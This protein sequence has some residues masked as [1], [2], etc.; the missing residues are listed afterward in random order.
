[1]SVEA[2][3]VAVLRGVVLDGYGVRVRTK[4]EDVRVVAGFA[5]AHFFL[6]KSLEP[7]SELVERTR[8][9]AILRVLGEVESF[10]TLSLEQGEFDVVGEQEESVGIGH[11]C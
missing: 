5:Q 1:M 8:D 4:G 11:F 9:M 2:R 3:L 6:R 10:G 7:F